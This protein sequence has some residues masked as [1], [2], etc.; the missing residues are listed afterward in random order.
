MTIDIKH[1]IRELIYKR[2]PISFAKSGDDIQLFKLIKQN[3]PGVYVDI[4]CWHPI[5]ASNT[6]FFYLRGWKGICVDPNP[7]IKTIFKKYRKHDVFV[8]AAISDIEKKLNYYSLK[9]PYNSMNTVNEDFIKYHN[10]ESEI[11]S[12]EEIHSFSLKSVLEQNLSKTD[13]LD[14]FDIDVEGFDIEVLKS[15]DW[16]KYRPKI[17]MI[18]SRLNLKEDINSG[19]VTYLNGQGYRFIG[20][21]IIEG[22]LGNLFLIDENMI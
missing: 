16:K 10:L 14:F 22:D 15:N 3:T 4:G 19:I 21:T 5:K 6:Y 18:E 20:K 12:V 1:K 13:R 17:I 2:Y 11:K 7:E 9:K 8:N